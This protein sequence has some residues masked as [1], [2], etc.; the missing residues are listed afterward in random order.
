[1][2]TVQPRRSASTP[3]LGLIAP[4]YRQPDRIGAASRLMYRLVAVRSRLSWTW[5]GVSKGRAAIAQIV[6]YLAGEGMSTRAIAPIVG[7]DNATVHR[8]KQ[9][10]TDVT[11]PTPVTGLDG[12]TYTPKAPQRLALLS[13]VM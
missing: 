12:K 8:D 13:V 3:S 1:M 11:T 4:R 7:V 5:C 6:G 2:A 10:V 9:V